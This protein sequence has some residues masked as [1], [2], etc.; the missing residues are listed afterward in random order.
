MVAAVIIASGWCTACSQRTEFIPHPDVDADV[1]LQ[2]VP[3][4]ATEQDASGR[5]PNHADHAPSSVEEDH[6]DRSPHAERVDRSAPLEQQPFVWT[7]RSREK[8]DRSLPPRA[9]GAHVQPFPTRTRHHEPSHSRSL[10]AAGDATRRTSVGLAG[11]EP[12]TRGLKA[13]CS[14]QAELQALYQRESYGHEDLRLRRLP[15]RA[16]ASSETRPERTRVGA[17]C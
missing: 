11:F 14:N 1:R 4:T 8:S 2:H 12:A 3:G 13:P 16:S 6:R 17:A 7:N 10:A 5:C 9:S 15:L